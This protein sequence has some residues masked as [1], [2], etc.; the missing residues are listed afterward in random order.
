MAC[1]AQP[2]QCVEAVLNQRL[3]GVKL[4]DQAVCIAAWQ[5]R[6]GRSRQ[7]GPVGFDCGWRAGR[8]W[9]RWLG[10]LPGAVCGA[11]VWQTAQGL[12]AAAQHSVAHIVLKRQG[13]HGQAGSIV[14]DLLLRIA[15]VVARLAPQF[16]WE[17]VAY[18]VRKRCRA[19]LGCESALLKR[20]RALARGQNL[21]ALVGAAV[22]QNKGFV[23]KGHARLGQRLARGGCGKALNI[24]DGAP[25]RIG[26]IRML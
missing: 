26:P 4:I 20:E 6:L 17:L 8:A 14:F 11:A 21:H 23:A 24:H 25:L 22:R 2:G 10:F 12:L 16:F 19:G 5:G 1:L 9:H 13:A 3:H 18:P 15:I 7:L